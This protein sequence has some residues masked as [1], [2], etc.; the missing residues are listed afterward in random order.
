MAAL[1]ASGV[2]MVMNANSTYSVVQVLDPF[3]VKP[4]AS[5]MLKHGTHRPSS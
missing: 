4:D 5:K 2:P 1:L 3:K